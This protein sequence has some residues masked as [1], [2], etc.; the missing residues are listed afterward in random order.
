MVYSRAEAEALEVA[1][2]HVS[3]L[4]AWRDILRSGKGGDMDTV[5]DHIDANRAWVNAPKDFPHACGY[6]HC[7]VPGCPRATFEVPKRDRSWAWR[8]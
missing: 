3:A 2:D 4:M 5:L 1:G 8:G 7:K 6:E